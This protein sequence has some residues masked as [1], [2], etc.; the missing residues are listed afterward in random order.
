MDAGAERPGRLMDGPKAQ[1]KRLMD[2]SPAGRRNVVR[3]DAPGVADLGAAAA[4]MSLMDE[5]I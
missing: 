1:V 3:R 2:E 5:E 4:A